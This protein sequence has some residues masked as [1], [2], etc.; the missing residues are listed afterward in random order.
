MS[1]QRRKAK[2]RPIDLATDENLLMNEDVKRLSAAQIALCPQ[3]ESSEQ[4]SWMRLATVRSA[5]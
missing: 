2:P 4:A 1:S 3:A 5:I